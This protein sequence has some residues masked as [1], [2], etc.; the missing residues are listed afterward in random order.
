MEHIETARLTICIIL[1]ILVMPATK[2]I[3]AAAENKFNN[4]K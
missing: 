4:R 2:I 3:L 1:A